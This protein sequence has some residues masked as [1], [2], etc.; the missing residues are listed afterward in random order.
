MRLYSTKNRVLDAVYSLGALSYAIVNDFDC[1]YSKRVLLVN[2]SF[3][4]WVVR[5]SR[6]KS[7]R[8]TLWCMPVRNIYV[9]RPGQMIRKTE[10]MIGIAVRRRILYVSSCYVDHKTKNLYCGIVDVVRLSVFGWLGTAKR[11]RESPASLVISKC[12]HVCCYRARINYAE[13]ARTLKWWKNIGLDDVF[14]RG[15]RN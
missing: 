11:E 1:V 15:L 2:V 4:Y 5:N 7:Y 14:T 3:S 13:N 9:R 12:A 6:R 8:L 10:S